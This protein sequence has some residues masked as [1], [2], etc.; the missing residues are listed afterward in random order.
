[1]TVST[2]SLI[3]RKLSHQSSQDERFRA[4]DRNL[5]RKYVML[6]LRQAR[7]AEARR[8][9][10]GDMLYRPRVEICDDPSSTRITAMLELPGV[11]SED[12]R[13]QVGTNDKL[14]VSGERRRKISPDQGAD[15]K[16]PLQEIRYGKYER[17]IDLPQGTMMS[18]ISASID[19]GLL[20]I[21][22]P[23]DP[24]IATTSSTERATE[25]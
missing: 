15:V 9:R 25:P 23:R 19:D 11:K 3:S 2:S 8:L 5:A 22:W 12:I 4:L 1:M 24:P 14:R 10:E 13:L 7:M 18:T 6:L 16:Y 21:S 20:L 17:V